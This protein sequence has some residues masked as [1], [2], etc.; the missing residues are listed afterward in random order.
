[1]NDNCKEFLKNYFFKKWKNNI[2]SEERLS[3]IHLSRQGAYGKDGK[4][5]SIHTG[6]AKVKE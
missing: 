4:D 5:G 6:V 2:K 1:M 3:F